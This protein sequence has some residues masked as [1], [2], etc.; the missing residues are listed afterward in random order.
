MCYERNRLRHVALLS[1]VPIF[2]QPAV[3][4]PA[5]QSSNTQR[6]IRHLAQPCLETD[7]Q[8]VSN[9][10]FSL[11]HC[12]WSLDGSW[13]TVVQVLLTDGH[14]HGHTIWV[15]AG[16]IRGVTFHCSCS[17]DSKGELILRL[18]VSPMILSW[19]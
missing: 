18:T 3:S 11:P 4:A 12:A 10:Y 1:H 14:G 17:K 8:L 9:R 13:V 6:S 16:W 19:I 15:L 7:R 5:G 2:D